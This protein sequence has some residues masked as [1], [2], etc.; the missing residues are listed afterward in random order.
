M[1]DTAELKA[2]KKCVAE[3]SRALTSPDNDL[4]HFLHGNGFI[5]DMRDMMPSQSGADNRAYKLVRRIEERVRFDPQSYHALVR[6]LERCPGKYESLLFSLKREF[7]RQKQG[8]SHSLLQAAR[9]YM[10]CVTLVQQGASSSGRHRYYRS[11]STKRTRSEHDY[12]NYQGLP[13][14]QVST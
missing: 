3:L 7:E 6:H 14:Y 2:L 12:G 4:I 13:R 10:F 9:G 11:Q 5:E 8:G 1:E